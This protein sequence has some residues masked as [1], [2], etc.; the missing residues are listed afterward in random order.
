VFLCGLC[1]LVYLVFPPAP[2]DV[3]ILGLDARPGEGNLARTDSILLLGVNPSRLQSSLLSIPRD[4]FLDVPGY[5]LQRINTINVL[6]EMEAEGRGVPL[7]RESVASNFGINV[8]RFALLNF[9]GFVELINAIGGVTIDV[10]RAIADDFY[11][12]EDGGTIQI[13]FD[14]G[15]QHMD[16]ERALIYARTRHGDDDY[17]RAERQ[18]QVI[19]AVAL[20]LR[21]PANWPAAVA[22]LNRS[23]TT[24]LNLFDVFAIAPSIVLNAGR[25]ERLVIDRAYITSRDGVA[26]PNYA[27]L[28]PW[29][30]ERYD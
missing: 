6:G 24:D 3:L 14:P 23:V 28:S 21:N 25:F 29:I 27:A 22:F 1:A 9:D 17:A 26:V 19:E 20:R 18:Q 10:E 2:L 15:V 30:D 16:G 12:T 7:M 11:P 13:R 8:D 5:G 4:L